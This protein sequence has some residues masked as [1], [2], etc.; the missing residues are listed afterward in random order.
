MNVISR[1][2]IGLLCAIATTAFALFATAGSAFAAGTIEG[3]VVDVVTEVGIDGAEVCAVEFAAEFESCEE[4]DG[5]GDYV[6]GLPTP[7]KCP[8]TTA[9]FQ[10]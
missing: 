7:T 1:P 5:N 9:R 4:T 8:L 3:R 2:R 10:V 6:I